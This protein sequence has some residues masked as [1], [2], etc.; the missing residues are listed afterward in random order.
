MQANNPQSTIMTSQVNEEI[1]D[2]A[3]TSTEADSSQTHGHESK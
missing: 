2:I 1:A 3:M